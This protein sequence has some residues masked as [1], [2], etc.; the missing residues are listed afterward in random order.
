MILGESICD[1]S[2]TLMC[3]VEFPQQ[4]IDVL[5]QALSLPSSTNTNA[6]ETSTSE[7]NTE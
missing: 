5:R 2:I 7:Q 1:L 4:L 6:Y 3:V